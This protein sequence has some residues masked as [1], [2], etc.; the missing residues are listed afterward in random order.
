MLSRRLLYSSSLLA[1]GLFPAN[2]ALATPTERA[3]TVIEHDLHRICFQ[4]AAEESLEEIYVLSAP[5]TSGN[6][7]R[8]LPERTQVTVAGT[9]G[10]NW[11][12][13]VE[14]TIGYIPTS[15]LEICS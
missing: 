11:V 13:I 2:V 12:Q 6:I 1:C 7:V 9:H 4:I 5:S 14:P 3:G 15:Y 10:E 8:I